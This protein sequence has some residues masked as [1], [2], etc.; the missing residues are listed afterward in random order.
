MEQILCVICGVCLLIVGVALSKLQPPD[1]T[2]KHLDDAQQRKVD[3]CG[4]LQRVVR[5]INNRLISLIGGLIVCT[6]AIPHGRVWMLAWSVVLSMTLLCIFLAMID[7]FSSLL[8]YRW[9]LPT[10]IRRTL[11]DDSKQL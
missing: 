5:W 8:A 4:R 2:S 6:A 10:T 11:G 9:T 3:T 1:W 7:A